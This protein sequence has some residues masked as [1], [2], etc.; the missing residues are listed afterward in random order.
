[1]YRLAYVEVWCDVMSC[2]LMR[3]NWDER[4]DGCATCRNAIWSNLPTAVLLTRLTWTQMCGHMILAHSS[5]SYHLLST[6]ILNRSIDWEF[7]FNDK[8]TGTQV[9]WSVCMSV[10]HTDNWLSSVHLFSIRLNCI[11][12][13]LMFNTLH[14]ALQNPLVGRRCCGDWPYSYR[15]STTALYWHMITDQIHSPTAIPPNG[16]LEDVRPFLD[17]ERLI[18]MA[19]N[20]HHNV[21]SACRC[22]S[23]FML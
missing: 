2:C 4:K 7:R 13:F 11:L 10:G 14:C 12:S 18:M 22:E 3:L 19:V 16:Q 20:Q 1:M 17:Y 6:H 5:S 21:S 15:P 9:K 23:I 8:E